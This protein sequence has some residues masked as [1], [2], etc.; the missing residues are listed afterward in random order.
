M[1]FAIDADPVGRDGSGNETYLRGLL[2]AMDT[3]V[4]PGEELV[5]FGSRPEALAGLGLRSAS[6]VGCASGLRGELKLGRSISRR[7]VDAVLAHYNLP[8]GLRQPVATIVHDVAFLRVPK[9]FA[10]RQAL[11]LRLSIRRSVLRSDAIV[12]GSEFSKREL[13][14]SYPALDEDRVVVAPSAADSTYFERQSSQALDSVRRRYGLPDVFV[15]SVGNLQPR[16]NLVRTAEAAARCGVPLVAAGRRH[17]RR[18]E[19]PIDSI[20][21]LGYVPGP[22]LAA[23]YQLCTVFCYVSIYEGFGL[24]VLE[25]L[26]SGSV[27]VTSSTT[28]LPEVAGAAAVLADPL[29]VDSV[30]EALSRALGDEGLRRRLKVDG[31]T[32]AREYS[33]LTSG[34]LVLD[35]MRRLAG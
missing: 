17:G 9:T 26:A 14:E 4:E 30:T 10:R 31:P 18:L 1:R 21:W 2:G 6:V 13:L 20:R 12:T 22:D 33:W 7:D 15:L 25:A 24:P 5:L 16:K 3:L 11:R 32:R 27:V 19:G 28:A 8:L 29:S 35:R 34:G 23:L